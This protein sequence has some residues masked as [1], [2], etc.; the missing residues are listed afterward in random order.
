[1]S[2][3]SPLRLVVAGHVDH[4]KSTLVA[5]LV[6]D[7]GGLPEGKRE[8]IER[9]CAARGV[10]FEWSFLLDAF[11]AERDQA[12]TIDT[13][14][15]RFATPRR[16]FVI[17]DAPG[18]R[19]FLR[20]MV[21]GAAQAD[22]A[23][24]V[25]DARE[26]LREQSRRHAHILRLLGL[27]RIVVAVN[28][29]DAAGYNPE[30]FHQVASE[31][32]GY[33]ESIGLFPAHIVPVCA[34]TGENLLGPAEP[35]H[36]Y[37]GANLIE[38]L[39][40]LDPEQNPEGL[41]LRFPVQDVYRHNETRILAGRIE[42]GALAVGDTLIFSP[43]GEKARI[44][45]IALWPDDPGKTTARAGES[46][47]LILD[48]KI[49]VERG[50]IASHE[51]AAPALAQ[52]FP[53]SVFWFAASPLRTGEDY[54]LRYATCEAPVTVQAVTRVT[55]AAT[56][57]NK[58]GAE[59]SKGDVGEIILR[60][61]GPLALDAFSDNPETGRFVLYDGAQA[62]G[63]G[64]IKSEGLVDLRRNPPPKSGNIFAVSHLLTP[65]ARIRA[66][67]HS[68]AVVWLTGLSGA[69]KSTLAMAAEKI[70]FER[71]RRT[72]VLDG[73]NLRHGLCADLGF[74]PEDRAENIRRA[75]E[76]AALMADAGLIV[77]AAFISPWREGRDRARAAA[78]GKFH[79]VYVHA[80]LKTCESR[81]PKG[82]YKKARA[83]LISDFTGI[84][85]PY[86]SPENPDLVLDTARESPDFCIQS[87]V[88]YIEAQTRHSDAIKRKILSTP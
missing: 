18:H 23:L 37:N 39:E 73:D 87:L 71:G 34:R 35:L 61:R 68:G 72:Y 57:E 55:D 19:E 53:A 50:H 56:L 4:G 66:A 26:G 74:S 63:G 83:G 45:K 14:Q 79:E 58:P 44:A 46:V 9:A 77:L 21:S 38:A 51:T 24:L 82:L 20:N 54:T 65:E 2:A 48:E 85:S 62:A 36:W 86:E 3:N 7:T 75:G 78:H 13:T 1:M 67:G 84:D 29:M 76:V 47:G 5:R 16:S 59:I 32:Q 25:I 8:E 28:K 27:R 15:I 81:D 88:D 42:S 10:A 43:T 49:F 17:I 69:G 52:S 80:D 41:P 40:S 70:L 64:L 60:A 30:I 6:H 33:L 12:V 22:A 11:Q 31:A